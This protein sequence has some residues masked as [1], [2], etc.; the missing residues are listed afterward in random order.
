METTKDRL[1]EHALVRD[2]F[3]SDVR[4]IV[5]STLNDDPKTIDQTQELIRIIIEAYFYRLGEEF[6]QSVSGNKEIPLHIDT[7][8]NIV[9]ETAP[10]GHVNNKIPWSEF[11]YNSVTTLFASQNKETIELFR[12]LSNSVHVV[13]VLVRGSGRSA[14]DQ[15]TL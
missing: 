11:L 8:N 4:D 14:R 15:E 13:C 1:S 12:V 10:S 6:A 7:L 3:K 5:G 9:I 2:A